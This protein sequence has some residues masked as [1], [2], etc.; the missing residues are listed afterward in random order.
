MIIDSHCHLD[1]EPI[2]NSLDKTI[3]KAKENNV[4]FILT[5]GTT[6]KSYVKISEIISKYKNVYGSYGIHPHEANKH[7][8]IKKE[9]IVDKFKKNK[10][11]IGIGETGLDFF[12]EHSDKKSQSI[13]FEE[14]IVSAIELDVPLII[15]SRS[16]ESDTTN[17]LTKFK[18]KYSDL[19]FLIHCFTGSKTFAF[20]ILDLGGYI[21]ASGIITFK[22]SKELVEIFKLIPN[23]R[24]LIETDAPYLSPEP[25]RGKPNA[26]CN[27]I[28]T[29]KFLSNSKNIDFQDFCKITTKNFVDLFDIKIDE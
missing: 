7:L 17:I 18:K 28:H 10:K 19:K 24:L 2:V 25:L 3:S 15:H 4:E 1:Y 22:K 27:I 8:H 23:N 20:K 12:Y 21:S 16:A 14:H 9:F 11:L 29:A 26:P 13:L 5:I 6:D